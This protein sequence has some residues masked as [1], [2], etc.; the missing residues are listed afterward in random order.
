MLFLLFTLSRPGNANSFTDIFIG[1]V[2][3]YEKNCLIYLTKHLHNMAQIVHENELIHVELDKDRSILKHTWLK[4]P[5]SQEFRSTLLKV[6]DIYRNHQ[7]GFD[8]LKWLAD[9][10]KLGELTIADEEWLEDV[11]DPLIF[12]E[13]GVK[14][15]AVILGADIFADYPMEMFKLSSIQKNSELGVELEVFSDEDKAYKWLEKR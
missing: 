14:A 11:W 2:Q 8:N 5:S 13:A 4:K 12:R 9:T 3:P 7:P 15:H 6:L 1:L 10:V